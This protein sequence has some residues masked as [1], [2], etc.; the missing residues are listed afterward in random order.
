MTGWTT[1]A[2]SAPAAPQT[3]TPDPNQGQS[4]REAAADVADDGLQM[5]R[6][7]CARASGWFVRRA[8]PGWSTDPLL[9]EKVRDI[10]GLYMHPPTHAVV[11]C[12]DEKAQIQ[13]VDRT[14]LVLPMRPGQ[15]EPHARL[16]SL[17]RAS[18]SRNATT[19]PPSVLLVE[20]HVS[21]RI[22]RTTLPTHVESESVARTE[23]G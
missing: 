8:A 20:R 13:A 11:L 14:Q 21:C 2:T 18:V 22:A 19:F 12:V 15:V 10:V 1:A 9:I 3:R 4:R 7:V 23:H 6:P 17:P 5:A 16:P